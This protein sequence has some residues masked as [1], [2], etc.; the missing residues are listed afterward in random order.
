MPQEEPCA[1]LLLFVVSFVSLL[2]VLPF[3]AFS[4][5]LRVKCFSLTKTLAGNTL[6]GMSTK[7]TIRFRV[8]YSEIDKMGTF[9]NSHA[10]EWFEW[11]R[12]ELLRKIGCSYAEMEAKGFC[13]P[14]VEAHVEYLGR[15]GFDDLL[16]MTATLSMIGKA[17]VRFDLTIDQ[18][19]AAGAESS[20]PENVDASAA[21]GSASNPAIGRPVA[22]GFTIHA[23]TDPHGKPLRP[24]G[25]LIDAVAKAQD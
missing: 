9:Y 2:V 16:V 18:A 19:P 6:R 5:P 24:P 1:D 15:A 22:R 10:L 17:R 21:A 25:W 3:S 12:V 23:V 14:L 20:A 11:G 4:A 13:L 7:S 8:R